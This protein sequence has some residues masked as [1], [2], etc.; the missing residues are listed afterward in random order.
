MAE[1]PLNQPATTSELPD[2]PVLVGVTPDHL[3]H[4]LAE[5]GRLAAAFGTTLLVAHVDVTRFVKNEDPDG[6]VPTFPSEVDTTLSSKQLDAVKA[7]AEQ[8]LGS[9]GAR[10]TVV[11]PFGDPATALSQVAEQTNA[12]LIVVGTRK[13]GIGE[14]IREFFTGSVAARLTHRQSRPVV[15]V[16]LGEPAG[17]D[18]DLWPEA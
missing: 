6:Y 3:E 7:T 16:P 9:T 14:G 5:A 1:E 8:V 13:R 18:Q 12:R 11:Q 17:V 4:V 2:Q 10:W 15:V